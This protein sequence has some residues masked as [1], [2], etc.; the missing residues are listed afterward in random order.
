[1]AFDDSPVPRPPR[2]GTALCRLEDLPDR[3]GK[4]L[5][6]GAGPD[7]PLGYRLFVVRE[8]EHV[9]SYVNLCPHM[10]LTLNLL[11]D[12]FVSLDREFIVCSNHGAQFRFEDG[13][14]VW[15]PCFGESLQA[16]RVEVRDGVV[17]VAGDEDEDVGG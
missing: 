10:S 6:F 14:C 3:D 16:V 17:R 7:D 1:V 2:G 12:R 8:G 5:V 4:E 13:Y 9:F 11:P 15:G